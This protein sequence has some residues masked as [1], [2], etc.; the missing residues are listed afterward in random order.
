MKLL[1]ATHN[2]G[3]RREY[4]AILTGLGV[5]LVDLAGLG[6][7]TVVPEDGATY[8][9]NAQAKARYYAHATG[10]LTLADD[11]GLEVDALDGAPGVYSARYG[12]GLVGRSVESDADRCRLLLEQMEG[13]P[14]ALRTARFRCV[15]VMVWPNGDEEVA[16]GVC[17]G[18]I[19]QEPRGTGGFGYDPVFIVPD[20]TATMAELAPEVKNLVSHRARAAAAAREILCRI[21]GT[22]SRDVDGS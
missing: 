20:H 8:I 11:S 2:K 3:K 16:E 14:D 17:E 6:I 1:V 10:L 7:D 19:A 18:R 22:D 4:A 13:M 15:I 5:D 21:I 9:E 12:T